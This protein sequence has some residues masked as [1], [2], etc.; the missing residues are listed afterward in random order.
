MSLEFASILLYIMACQS[1]SLGIGIQQ[2]PFV[3][4]RFSE[5]GRFLLP[6]NGD[7]LADTLVQTAQFYLPV[8]AVTETCRNDSNYLLDSLLHGDNAALENPSPLPPLT[9]DS[10]ASH[11]SRVNKYKDLG[12]LNPWDHITYICNK[13]NSLVGFLYRISGDF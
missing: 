8:H 10:R 11:F 1:V 7:I 2:S 9:T 3:I 4:Q 6:I 13:A 12:N 5:M